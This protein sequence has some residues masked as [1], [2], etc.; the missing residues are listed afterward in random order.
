MDKAHGTVSF[1]P[2]PDKHYL[3]LTNNE[4]SLIKTVSEKS[5]KV[6]V[7]LNSPSPMEIGELE[8]NDNIDAILWI[9]APGKKGYYG[10]A[11]VLTGLSPSGRLP[12]T[13][14]SDFLD[15]LRF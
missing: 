15:Y 5:D 9:G 6:I 3:E 7:I 13:Y 2:N 11:N 14:S 8:D 1:D 4:E 10:F 12:D